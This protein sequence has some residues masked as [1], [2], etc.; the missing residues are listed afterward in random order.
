MKKFN[1]SSKLIILILFAFFTHCTYAQK[2]VALEKGNMPDWVNNPQALYPEQQYIVGVGSGDTRKAAEYDAAGNIARVFKSKIKVDQTLVENYLESQN[3]LSASSQMLKRTSVNSEQNLKNIKI[4]RAYFSSKQ[5]VYYVLAYLNRAETA[6]FYRQD[7]Q[8]NNKKIRQYFTDAQQDK[9][10]LHR[11]AFLKKAL[12]LKKI[13]QLL[14]QQYQILT[15]GKQI[16]AEVSKNELEKSLMQL[17]DQITVELIADPGTPP[18]V[19]DYLKEMIGRLGFKMVAA[20][21]DFTFQYGL[22]VRETNIRRAHTKALS[23]KLTLRVKDNMN[24]STLKAFNIKKR[25]VAISAEEARSRMLLKVQNVLMKKFSKQFNF[26][27]M[28]L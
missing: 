21:A 4:A 19:R 8:Q 16:P 13:N 10:K 2:T 22:D 25:T 11:Y 26:Y 20:P 1:R 9:N 18:E 24:R 12:M 27:V 23:W 6:V 15:F 28:N 5:G 7:I 3:Q 14:N 17:K